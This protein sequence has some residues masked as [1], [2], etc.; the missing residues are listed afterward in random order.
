MATN[1]AVV[2]LGA[3]QI[4]GVRVDGV[5]VFRGVPYA[6]PPVGP[7]RFRPPQE[8][9][10]W[11]GV[12]DARNV[13][14]IA[15]QFPTDLEEM[16]GRLDLPQSEDCLTLN[17]WTP[18]PD[19]AHRPVMV[20]IHGG[21]YLN[22]TG[23]AEWFDGT[24]FATRHDVVLVTINYRLAVFGYLHLADLSPDEVG[25]GNCG[26]LDQIAA[27]QWVA[28]NIASFGGDP[29]NVTVFGESA[30]AMSVGVLLGTPEAAGL[31]HRSIL[32]SGA[33][34]NVTTAED[35]TAV[36]VDVL[37]TL[38][39]S[40]DVEGV[41][42]LRELPAS[43]IM[44]A[45]GAV[46]V[47]HAPDMAAARVVPTFAPVVDGVVLPQEPLRAIREGASSSVPVMIG[48]N[49]DEM[50]IMRLL[51]KSIYDF[52]DEEIE[53][54][55]VNLFGDLSGEALALYRGP[56]RG[57]TENV[58]TAVDTDRTF[59]MPAIALAEAHV[60]AGGA[61]WLYF[62]TWTTTA[63]GGRMGAVHTLEIPFVFNN[64]ALGAS[65]ELTGGPPAHAHD[66][67]ERMHRTWAQFA[68]HGD[69]T[70]DGLPAWAPYE[71]EQRAT[72]IFD[73]E[74]AVVSDPQRDRR[75][76]WNTW[77]QR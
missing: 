31:F 25:S 10:P 24:S 2:Q 40:P 50:E 20:W 42:R 34:S 26:L 75:V 70:H 47:S 6:Q 57:T 16:Q 7:L 52:G 46:A 13:G 21:A 30:G 38:G 8:C 18:A 62:F 44:A 65:P 72:M 53:R 49:R 63:F 22:G 3:G 12:R 54:R 1:G 15:H 27:L 19:G 14:P 77:A 33:A 29:D 71:P 73:S 28:D 41:T 60:A 35:A 11:E 55:A 5:S 37:A 61:T 32:Q 74:C 76:L 36:A 4:E 9:A 48:T 43:D 69:P 23:A 64:F 45:Y 56:G 39:L 67:G 58:W 59:L 68:R 17:I 66:L 51:D